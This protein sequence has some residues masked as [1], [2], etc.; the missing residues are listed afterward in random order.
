MWSAGASGTTGIIYYSTNNGTNWTS[1]FTTTAPLFS[2]T[3]ANVNCGWAGGTAG[4]I[5]KYH[6]IINDINNNNSTVPVN[7]ALEQNYPNPFNPTTTINY[8]IP[9][10][11]FV[12]LK[13]YSVLGNEVMSIVNEQQSAKNYTYNVD[14]SKLS[15]GVYYYTLRAGDFS[16]TKKLMLIK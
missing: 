12:T 10:A 16:S 4:A 14:F 6:G 5:F 2:L 3:L 13:V 8:S 7:Y 15:S 1:Q 11:S 9:K